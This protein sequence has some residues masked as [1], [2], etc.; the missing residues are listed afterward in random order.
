MFN[1][2]LTQIL[3][4]SKYGT[5]DKSFNIWYRFHTLW[6]LSSI[7]VLRRDRFY[8]G[9][10]D[11]W[12]ATWQNQ[13]NECAP[14]EDADQ[15]GHPPILTRVFAVRMKKAWVFRYPLCA[16]R[17]LWSD[18][19]DAQIDLSLRWAHSHFVGFVMSRLMY[20]L[21][22]HQSKKIKEMFYMYNSNFC[23][24]AIIEPD[25]ILSL[26]F[27]WFKMYCSLLGPRSSSWPNLQLE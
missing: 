16:Q 8:K 14:S 13:Q 27:D 21:W 11:I 24:I 22:F 2:L 23:C 6:S 10:H 19:A 5:K 3:G 12:A 26:W 17:R 18:W 4:L 7:T 9:Y 1:V 25:I 15:S 20:L